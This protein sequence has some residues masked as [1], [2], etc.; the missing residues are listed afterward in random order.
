MGVFSRNTYSPT[1]RYTGVRL[2]MGVP[3][4]DAD[5]NES[6]DIR[7]H[8]LRNILYDF[9]GDGA[10]ARL[11]NSFRIVANDTPGD[12]TI[13]PGIY[14]VGGHECI[15]DADRMY[16]GQTYAGEAGEQLADRHGVAPLDPLDPA[17]GNRTDCVYLDVWE[18]EV[19]HGEDPEL[20]NPELAI[21]TAV[22]LKREW[23]VR[24]HVGSSEVPPAP[25][26]H[27]HAIRA[28][29]FRPAGEPRIRPEHIRDRRQ[30]VA[31]VPRELR[32]TSRPGE[33][34]A[35]ATL[36]A[37]LEL[38]NRTED[39]PRFRGIWSPESDTGRAQI[40]L[41]S[42]YSDLVIASGQYNNN[43]GSTLSFATYNPDNPNDF[44]KFVFNQ[45][46]WGDRKHYLEIGYGD[47]AS[48]NPHDYAN[49]ER[50][51]LTIDGLRK[52]VGVNTRTPEVAFDVAGDARVRG[53]FNTGGDT[54]ITGKLNVSGA[55]VVGGDAT[56][57]GQ[58]NVQKDAVFA[59]ALQ[60]PAGNFQ[61][62]PRS[63]HVAGDQNLFYPIAFHDDGW[64]DGP[65]QLE[66]AR[67][68]VHEDREWW[69]A[70]MFHLEYHASNW[71]HGAEF[72][73]LRA[74]QNV[75]VFI[76]G[77]QINPLSAHC[78]IWLRGSTT[79]R[80]RSNHRASLFSNAATNFALHG[81]NYAIKTAPDPAYENLSLDLTMNDERLVQGDLH[82]DRGRLRLG[83]SRRLDNGG[84][85]VEFRGLHTHDVN[86]RAQL[87]LSSNYSD[88]VIASSQHNGW[89]GSTL[90]FATYNPGNA[91]DYRKFVLNQG[92]WGGRAHMLELGYGD[93]AHPN[94]HA[95]VDT[96]TVVAAFDG[97]RKRLGVNTRSPEVTLDV[98]GEARVR[99][100][101]R[102]DGAGLFH[103]NITLQSPNTENIYGFEMRRTDEENRAHTWMFYH[104]N[105]GYG[106]NSMQLW[107]YRTDS[108][109]ASCGG[110]VADGAMCHSRL[111]IHEGGKVEIQG[112]LQVNSAVRMNAGLNVAGETLLE[113]QLNIAGIG[114]T[115][116]L[117]RG[118]GDKDVHSGKI[119]F[120]TF[121]DGLDIV[122]AGS[123][124]TRRITF[125]AQNGS[126]FH[127]AL[128][129]N[130]DT[131]VTGKLSVGQALVWPSGTTQTRPMHFQTG[132]TTFGTQ[133][134]VATIE[135]Y[136][137]LSGFTEVPQ[138]F[139]SPS[140]MDVEQSR[141][142]RLNT[143]VQ[144]VSPKGFTLVLAC[145]ADT[146][147]WGTRVS[148]LAF[149]Y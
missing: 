147:L 115:I 57:N 47:F 91:D 80:W 139:V 22:R 20:L 28:E 90:T 67:A 10:P 3:I 132:A 142:M 44:R 126:V 105:Q 43:H 71:G 26:G 53:A 6:E 42:S 62:A 136:V 39:A 9:L 8:E 89:H 78:V 104:M 48:G 70:L 11:P 30:T 81:G 75:R 41:D 102:V 111:T 17:G 40:M 66:I 54:T 141:N 79:Y 109:G 73:R 145:W 135:V 31:S 63:F 34:D 149:G 112:N 46:N 51:V 29:I 13:R 72:W 87:V 2:Q 38:R 69:G 83:S 5:W 97:I 137:P 14:L 55:T 56:M 106:R 98:A 27:A 114:A 122:G 146:I 58:L 25:A 65:L 131:T 127:G 133:S 74:T 92:N 35:V 85:H 49:A 140:L 18:R 37:R 77:F 59:G 117:G 82:I 138:I 143:Y 128:Q 134:G 93:F 16:S 94:P 86:G 101:L 95:Y 50:T 99:G 121:S 52:R 45:G 125:H 108:N 60:V 129:V 88:L 103:S 124:S 24:V 107:E 116:E 119:G 118:V 76:G 36:D 12:F 64:L 15:L 84:G 4:A 32:I 33:R 23:V 7:K 120:R 61:I 96:G 113:R 19:D 21:A 100:N 148:W 68:N 1:K 123:G 144:N 130:G 110:N